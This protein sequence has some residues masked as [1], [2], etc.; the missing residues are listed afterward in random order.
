MCLEDFVERYEESD[1]KAKRYKD[2]SLVL[3]KSLLVLYIGLIVLGLSA[4]LIINVLNSTFDLQWELNPQSI[5]LI[6]IIGALV[7]VGSLILLTNYKEKLELT[8]KIVAYHYLASSI[9]EYQDNSDVTQS[10]DYLDTFCQY[11][12]SSSTNI[13]HPDR[14]EEIKQY[15]DI[16]S[17]L[18]TESQKE[19]FENTYTDN[20]K[21]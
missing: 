4:Q 2:V 20:I 1:D 9:K 21:K 17:E 10:I 19:Q 6:L 14:K 16:L 7:I 15:L 3:D 12:D 11:I 13:L 5:I 18:D 8:D